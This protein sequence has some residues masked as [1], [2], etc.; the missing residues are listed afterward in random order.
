[1]LHRISLA[2]FLLSSVC[3]AQ[4]SAQDAGNTPPA[5]DEIQLTPPEDV[6]ANYEACLLETIRIR[7]ELA[8]LLSSIQDADTAAAAVP[9]VGETMERYHTA[10]NRLKTLPQPD[11]EAFHQLEMKHLAYFRPIRQKLTQNLLRITKENFFGSQLLYLH[12]SGMISV[13]VGPP[14]PNAEFQSDKS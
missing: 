1:M 2:L 3:S 11:K 13:Q 6:D 5:A 7:A 14:L 4:L 8:E 12:L 9:A 10:A